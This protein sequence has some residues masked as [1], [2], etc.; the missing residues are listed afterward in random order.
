[1]ARTGSCAWQTQGEMV[2]LHHTDEADE[3]WG[4]T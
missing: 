4:L 2:Y 3:T 1:M